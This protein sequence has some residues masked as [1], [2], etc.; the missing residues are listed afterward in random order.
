MTFIK[1]MLIFRIMIEILVLIV[2]WCIGV[3]YGNHM[4]DTIIFDPKKHTPT[5]KFPIDVSLDNFLRRK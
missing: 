5:E 1:I 2:L 3:N 4:F